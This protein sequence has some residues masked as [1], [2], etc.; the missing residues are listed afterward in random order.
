VATWVQESV[1]VG[2]KTLDL[3]LT[4]KLFV[5][6][7]ALGLMVEVFQFIAYA[8]VATFDDPARIATY[9]TWARAGAR[10][11]PGDPFVRDRPCSR[12]DRQD[13]RVPVLAAHPDR[14]DGTL[15][16]GMEM[17]STLHPTPFRYRVSTKA[18]GLNRAQRL[19]STLWL[20]MLV[21]AL[22]AF[23]VG[24]VLAGVRANEVA[25]GGSPDTVAALGQ[26]VTAAN[27]VG[28]ASVFAAISFAIARILGVFR[29]GGGQIQEAAGRKVETLRM[30]TSG[31]VFIGLMAMA[32]M[33][34][35]V[36]VA[37]HVVAGA[38]IAG[39]SADALGRSEQW[40]IWLEGA[41]RF[42]IATYLLAI[43]FGLSTIITALRFQAVRI[44]ELPDE[45]KVGS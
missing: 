22:M 27:F 7:M 40:S 14:P 5:G 23:P 4:A 17:A 24:V 3:P 9:F 10:G 43:A 34:L 36:A 6:L 32:M 44:R 29:T 26:F 16:G 18:Q 35:V 2:V 41:R 19:G 31:K 1:G 28:F 25:N 42:G 12:H 38:A 39:G 13:A 45:V 30:P 8:V 37:L 15:R 21:T 11:G 33:I 20:P